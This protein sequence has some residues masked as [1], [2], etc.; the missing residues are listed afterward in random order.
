MWDMHTYT[1]T[2]IHR[3]VFEVK[4]FGISLDRDITRAYVH[5]HTHTGTPSR[6]ESFAYHLN[7][8]SYVLVW[9]TYQVCSW[10]RVQ[11]DRLVSYLVSWLPDKNIYVVFKSLVLV[12]QIDLIKINCM[13]LFFG[14]SYKLFCDANIDFMRAVIEQK[15]HMRAR[16]LALLVLILSLEFWILAGVT[17]ARP[18]TQNS[19]SAS[20][21][22]QSMQVNYIEHVHALCVYIHMHVHIRIHTYIC[23]WHKRH[24]QCMRSASTYECMY[25]IS[26]TPAHTF[27]SDTHT[28]TPNTQDTAGVSALVQTTKVCMSAFT[29]AVAPTQHCTVHVCIT[30][31]CFFAR[32]MA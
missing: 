6:P 30:R 24:C 1:Q 2:Y 18:G 20:V 26:S 7:A 8:T 19:G 22:A 14:S 11:Y 4:E 10:L 27:T 28:H 25:I 17:N 31:V 12:Q 29:H 32:Y 16:L 23:I 15:L 21:L 9:E 3:H 13:L 5:T